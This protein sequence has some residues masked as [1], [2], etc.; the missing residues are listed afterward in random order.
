[1]QGDSATCH[2]A[3]RMLAPGCNP[4][5]LLTRRNLQVCAHVAASAGMAESCMAAAATATTSPPAAAS[6][7]V[8]VRHFRI[9]VSVRVAVAAPAPAAEA[10]PTRWPSK[11]TAKAAAAA[12]SSARASV[13]RRLGLRDEQRH[14]LCQK[15]DMTRI[16]CV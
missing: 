4:V 10:A 16:H 2:Q 3:G 5:Q 15:Q 11:A 9:A 7:P 8:S 6:V 14:T 12:T 13:T 1:M